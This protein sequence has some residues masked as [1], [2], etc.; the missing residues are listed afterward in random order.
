MPSEACLF[1]FKDGLTHNN[2]RPCGEV[3]EKDGYIISCILNYLGLDWE[4]NFS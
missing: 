2:I 1:L 3:W 4:K